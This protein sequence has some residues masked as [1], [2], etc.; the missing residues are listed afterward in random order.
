MITLKYA[1]VTQSPAGAEPL[2][3]LTEIANGEADKIRFELSSKSTL[4][5]LACGKSYRLKDGICEVEFTNLKDG[6]I[7][8]FVSDGE[9]KIFLDRIFKADGA[10]I[11]LPSDDVLYERLRRAQE[12]LCD[13]LRCLEERISEI[14]RK[15]S[16]NPLFKFRMP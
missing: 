10:I 4:K 14:E 2:Y 7:D 3:V 15:M 6:A 9:N 16:P 5:L 8:F 1:L 12:E 11:R 13:A